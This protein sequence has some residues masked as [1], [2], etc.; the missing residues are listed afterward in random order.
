[1]HEENKLPRDAGSGA[2]QQGQSPADG[3]PAQPRAT[4]RRGRR[5]RRLNWVSFDDHQ[6]PATNYLRKG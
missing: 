4:P 6:P 3:A 1:M 5:P 2:G